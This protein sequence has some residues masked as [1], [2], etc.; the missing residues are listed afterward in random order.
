MLARV[1]GKIIIWINTI[2]LILLSCLGIISGA[3]MLKHQAMVYEKYRIHVTDGTNVPL[4]DK[5]LT[6]TNK[7]DPSNQ[8]DPESYLYMLNQANND[9]NEFVTRLQE[10]YNNPQVTPDI[11]E[12][13]QN[14][15][16]SITSVQNNYIKPFIDQNEA[17]Y[18]NLTEIAK[19]IKEPLQKIKDNI[20]KYA[21]PEKMEKTYHTIAIVF[22]AVGSSI[23][24]IIL[25][26]VVLRF[27]LYK[28]VYGILVSRFSFKEKLAMKINKILNKYPEIRHQIM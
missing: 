8:E 9:I 22:I 4:I 26:L 24:F 1:F 21:T 13:I 18:Q 5:A 12:Q 3:L 2:F 6:L 16:N 23:V 25:L 11:K 14:A 10:V 28:S 19:N 15:I 17:T 7:I 27:A 20:L